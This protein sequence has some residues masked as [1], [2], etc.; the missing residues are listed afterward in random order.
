MQVSDT[1]FVQM[2]SS[3]HRL[4]ET[5]PAAQPRDSIAHWVALGLWALWEYEPR[6]SSLADLEASDQ[7]GLLAP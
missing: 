3:L 6:L 1:G 2:R 5:D 7:L 4:I